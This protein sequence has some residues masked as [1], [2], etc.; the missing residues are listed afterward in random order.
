MAVK[1]LSGDYKWASEDA[2]Y[3]SEYAYY[4]GD[5]NPYLFICSLRVDTLAIVGRQSELHRLI[6]WGISAPWRFPLEFGDIAKQALGADETVLFLDHLQHD[7]GEW[8]EILVPDPSSSLVVIDAVR[9]PAEKEAEKKWSQRPSSDE[10]IDWSRCSRYSRS[11]HWDN[12]PM[13][14]SE[15]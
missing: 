11:V 15:E 8:G 14:R 4:Q 5:G 9:L 2:V 13:V 12:I 7:S 3:A 10:W 6:N 1:A